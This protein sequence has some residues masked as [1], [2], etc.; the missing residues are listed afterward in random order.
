MKTNHIF[1]LLALLGGLFAAFTSHTERNHIYPTWKFEKSRVEGVRVHYI[2]PHHLADLLYEKQDLSLLDARSWS[3]YSS[4]HIPT[5][6]HFDAD[7]KL[8][9]SQNAESTILYGSSEDQDI[10]TLA[11][12][13]PGK[14]YVLKGGMEAW[15]SMVLFPDMLEYQV[16]NSDQ[17]M[18]LLRRCAFFGGQAQ[19]T[20]VLNLNVRESR[21]REGC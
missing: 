6:L 1:A 10:Y 13:L 20:Q 12:D 7:Q 17:L 15:Y 9:G 14:V 3:E 18:Q 11:R 4:Y 8:K 16:R 2:S 19:N 5:A 21:Y